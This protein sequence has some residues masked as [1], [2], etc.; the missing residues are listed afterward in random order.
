MKCFLS[1]SLLLLIIVVTGCRSARKVQSAIGKKDT[2]TTT[3]IDN[4]RADSILYIRRVLEK[5]EENKITDFN[6]FSAKIK[7]D[8]KDKDGAQPELTVFVRMKKDS[9]IWLSINATILSY[10][11]L[12]ILITPDSVKVMN[13]KD[14]VLQLRSVSYLQE[15]TKLP[16]DFAILQDFLLGNPVYLDSNVVA[17]KKGENSV[18]L[19]NVGEYFKH[20]ITLNS[21]GFQ[22]EQSKLDDV[23]P[24]RNRTC[25]LRY[26]GYETRS[27]LNFSTRRQVSVSEKSKLDVD[28]DFKQYSFN[29]ILSYPFNVSKKYKQN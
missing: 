5:L 8:Y 22:L 20:F 13:R 3:I 15:L 23:D 28:M 27:G 21:A 24:I 29:E 7:V 6:T 1:V 17:Y 9:I 19:M 14:K 18:M 26:S 25:Y 2:T 16:F 4:G 12:R 11:A 10:E